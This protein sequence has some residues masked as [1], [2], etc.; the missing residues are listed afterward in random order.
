[1]S[2]AA[3]SGDGRLLVRDAR[4]SAV[5]GKNVGTLPE[6]EHAV[7]SPDSRFVAMFGHEVRVVDT[8]SALRYNGA[9]SARPP[10][11]RPS[12][13]RRRLAVVTGAGGVELWDWQP[14]GALV[15]QGIRGGVRGFLPRRAD[16][17]GGGDRAHLLDTASG[18]AAGAAF[19]GGGKN[20]KGVRGTH[21]LRQG[22]RGARA[23]ASADGL[24]CGHAPQARRRA[25]DR[26]PRSLLAR[27]DLLA[28]LQVGGKVRLVDVM[29]GTNLG[30]LLDQGGGRTRNPA[31]ARPGV[32]RRR[33]GGADRGRQR[34]RQ[35]A[36]GGR[37][38][39]GGGGVREGGWAERGPV[40]ANR[41]H[42]AYRKV[43]P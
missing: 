17:G 20:A 29:S 40:A 16:A 22:G 39:D 9:R 12:L 30:A 11:R 7:F 34:R 8:A 35:A 41:T 31:A 33:V 28:A 36:R 37:G 42:A 32:H 24:G 5:G 13:R 26:Q 25:R 38:G 43:C 23:P 1:M 10:S 27:E 4:L 3:L 21:P 14:G 18:K 6:A 2:T 15:S 19:G